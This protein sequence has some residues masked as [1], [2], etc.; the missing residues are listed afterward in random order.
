MSRC[1]GD[2][3]LWLMSEGEGSRA[4]RVHVASCVAC[5]ARLRRLEADLGQLTSVLRAPPPRVAPTWPRPFRLRWMTAAA[6]LAAMLIVVW[7]GLWWQQ[8]A[9]PTLPMEAS[10]ESIWSFMDGVSAALFATVDPGV[11][12]SPDALPDLDDLQAALAGDWPCDEPLA[13]GDVGCDDQTF[14][15]LLGGQ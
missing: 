13:L 8:P 2:R 3:T 11:M 1:L 6:T 12:S 4:D 7:V 5:S 15:L 9:P 10:Q 14:A